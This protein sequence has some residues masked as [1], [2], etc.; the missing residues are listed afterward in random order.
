M[1]VSV[2]HR[3]AILILAAGMVAGIEVRR[4]EAQTQKIGYVDTK[5]ILSNMPEYQGIQEQLKQL[6]NEWKSQIDSLQNVI[7]LKEREYEAR[8]I[9]YT[10]EVQKQKLDEIS[11][12]KKLKQNLVDQKFGANGEYYSKQKELLRPLQQ[13]IME[14]VD[15]IAQQEG[16]DFIFDRSGDYSFLYTRPEWNISDAVLN[17]MGI[18]L[19][20]TG[21]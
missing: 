3:I 4:A 6:S 19:N 10:P 11:S 17:E 21:N 2:Q 5:Y 9:L 8:E 15:K 16:Y 14:A 12:L 7:D 18:S 13:K 1:G 20:K